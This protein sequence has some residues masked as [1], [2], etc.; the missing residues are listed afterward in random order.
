EV[1]HRLHEILVSGAARPERIARQRYEKRREH[2]VEES[3][4]R[5]HWS[6]KLQRYERAA[7]FETL[8]H[9]ADARR[10]VV[11]IAHAESAQNRVERS[12]LDRRM[13]RVENDGLSA[14]VLGDRE[15]QHG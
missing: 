8:V 6:K 14:Q 5:P 2:T 4:E 11:E 9:G 12:G 13:Q 3:R 1:P 10:R 15:R 7:G